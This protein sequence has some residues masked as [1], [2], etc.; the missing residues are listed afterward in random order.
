M[1]WGRGLYAGVV[2]WSLY[3]AALFDLDGVLTPTADVHMH[4]WAKMFNEFLAGRPGQR[5]Y[6]DDDYYAC[7]DGKPRFEGVQSFLTSRGIDLPWGEVDDPTSAETV[8]G[9]GN[10][11]NEA[12][13][14]VLASEGVAP[15][16]G[17][18]LLLDALL[19]R[20]TKVAVVSSS[21]NAVKVLRTAGI[22]ADFPVIVDGEVADREGLAGKP[23]PATFLDAADKLGVPKERAVVFEDAVSGVQAG[24]AGH[25]GLVVGVNRGA[26]EQTLLDNG[27]DIVVPDLQ[28]ILP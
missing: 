16:P 26:G 15:Y 24:R 11:K 21:R 27:A 13:E 19:A 4:A 18:K 3:D 10:R 17:S 28:E 2:D 6:T 20:G 23:E 25:F 1:Q 9:L 14:Q 12:F 22:L 7:L 8:C 5:P